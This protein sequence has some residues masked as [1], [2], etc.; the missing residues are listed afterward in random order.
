MGVEISSTSYAQL[1]CLIGMAPVFCAAVGKLVFPDMAALGLSELL[2]STNATPRFRLRNGSVRGLAVAELLAALV[3]SGLLFDA[4]LPRA[5]ASLILA[6]FFLAGGIVGLIR[7]STLPCGCF[8]QGSVAPFGLGNMLWG[9][10]IGSLAALSIFIPHRWMIAAPSP[11]IAALGVL[12]S[13]FIL[14]QRPIV[15]ILRQQRNER[16]RVYKQ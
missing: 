4:V 10:G 11:I 6:T 1:L 3:G 2:R 7:G 16:D 14:N 13:A 5:V 9:V 15:D 8:G 12:I